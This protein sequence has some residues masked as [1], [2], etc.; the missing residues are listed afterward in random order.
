M[1]QEERVRTSR[2]GTQEV[3]STGNSG[4]R[5]TGG[6]EDKP[7]NADTNRLP[8]IGPCDLLVEILGPKVPLLP[9]ILGPKVLLLPEM[10]GPKA[11]LL[12]LVP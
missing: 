12:L 1:D 2:V 10:L 5:N 9:E 8:Y 3:R 7:A 11:L 4:H 6:A